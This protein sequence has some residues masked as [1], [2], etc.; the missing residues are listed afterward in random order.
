MHMEKLVTYMR[1]YRR[2]VGIEGLFKI[3]RAAKTPKEKA[4]NIIMDENGRNIPFVGA[5]WISFKS[6]TTYIARIK[7][8]EWDRLKP[9]PLSLQ[10]GLEAQKIGMDEI[11]LNGDEVVVVTEDPTKKKLFGM[12]V[13]DMGS[14]LILEI[15]ACKLGREAAEAQMLEKTGPG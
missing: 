3:N 1:F 6:R 13:M 7:E 4:V 10:Q 15:R 5:G 2:Q 12:A 14:K 9:K 8:H 11:Q